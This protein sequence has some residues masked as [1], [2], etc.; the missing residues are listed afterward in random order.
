MQTERKRD[1]KRSERE[2]QKY[3]HQ[4]LC[5]LCV[6]EEKEEEKEEEEEEEVV[7]VVVVVVEEEEEEE[8]ERCICTR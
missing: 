7:V 2:T 1:T 4:T 8:E 3:L 6:E 5:R